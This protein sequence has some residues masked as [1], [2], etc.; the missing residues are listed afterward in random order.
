[1]E[2]VPQGLSCRH[3]HNKSWLRNSISV[4][5]V[6][7]QELVKTAAYQKGNTKDALVETFLKMDEMLS[8]ESVQEELQALAGPRT[9]AEDEEE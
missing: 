8:Q 7:T 3:L 1:M 5:P 4:L 6:Q 2:P 9:N